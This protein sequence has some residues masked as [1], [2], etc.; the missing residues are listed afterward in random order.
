M[1]QHFFKCVYPFHVVLI[2]FPLSVVSCEKCLSNVSDFHSLLYL[3]LL[4][5]INRPCVSLSAVS[6]ILSISLHPIPP[7]LCTV[8][9][10]FQGENVAYCWGL[11]VSMEEGGAGGGHIPLRTMFAFQFPVSCL[12]RISHSV[13]QFIEK[14]SES[15]YEFD[16]DLQSERYVV[17]MFVRQFIKR[18]EDQG[19][20]M[21]IIL[22]K[23][24]GR[25]YI[26]KLQ[27]RVIL[28]TNHSF[29]HSLID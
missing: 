9:L 15:C 10:K 3:G 24:K 26:L 28:L 11:R 23:V 13:C 18:V 16:N 25:L 5:Q 17:R 12:Y 20:V 21:Y 7:P 8:P 6:K 19:R 4:V 1:P 2:Y 14:L 29:I 27:G 22:K